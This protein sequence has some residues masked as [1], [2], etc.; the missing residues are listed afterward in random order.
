MTNHLTT[1]VPNPVQVSVCT[2]V[3]HILVHTLVHIQFVT[4][5][6]GT[7]YSLSR[8][9][10]F[11][12]AGMVWVLS[13][14]LGLLPMGG[15]ARRC[16]LE[17]AQ[18]RCIQWHAW[19]L[20]PSCLCVGV[21]RRP[22]GPSVDEVMTGLNGNLITQRFKLNNKVALITGTA[23]GFLSLFLPQG[24]ADFRLSLFVVSRWLDW[25]Q[26]T[27]NMLSS[28]TAAFTH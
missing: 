26:S 7:G 21:C 2:C 14:Q 16:T 17:M 24:A 10:L 4:V 12:L 1:S 28:T 13:W 23:L 6:C 22:S 18:K 19:R 25:V 27:T 11:A 3:S 5:V 8:P 20:W 9:F 15:S